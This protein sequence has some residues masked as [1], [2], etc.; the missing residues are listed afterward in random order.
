MF[1]YFSY[2]Q[3][4]SKYLTKHINTSNQ[5][6]VLFNYDKY[7]YTHIYKSLVIMSIH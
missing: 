2:Q 1:Q 7:I 4:I 3:T 5:E 6:A